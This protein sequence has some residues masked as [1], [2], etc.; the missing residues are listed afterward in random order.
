V[1]I[2]LGTAQF[3]LDYGVS[4]PAGRT[5]PDE[6]A[7]ILDAA[8]RAGIEV[9]DTAPAYGES[10]A[11]LGRLAADEPFR[12]V[13]KTPVLEGL[14]GAEAAAAVRESLARSLGRLAR[15]A[16]WALLVHHGRDLDASRG[17]AVADELARAKDE[18]LAAKVGLSVY[19]A[20]ELDRAMDFLHPD[21]V[22]LPLSLFDQ[23]LLASGHL[24]A[25]ARAG[26][27]VHAR[28]VFLQG[29]LLMDPDADELPA[30]LRGL[31][32]RLREYRATLAAAGLGPLAGALAF[33]LGL[34]EVDLA[35]CGVNDAAQLGE[36]LEAAAAAPIPG[37]GAFAVG[38]PALID[39]SRWG[40]P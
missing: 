40:R 28:S 29:L 13:T 27:D 25:L 36:I 7:R 6:V 33:V 14:T 5:L 32:D 4:N 16:V 34:P 11:V 30:P 18:G 38:D 17:R 39:P 8:R 35:I 20:D 37:P 26:I 10:E 22:Q 3:G 23:R 19:D 12:V 24:G 31:K 15:P 2:G 9:L 21:V 1:R